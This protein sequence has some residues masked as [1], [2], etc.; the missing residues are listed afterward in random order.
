MT[1]Y[2]LEQSLQW[3]T[4][5]IIKQIHNKLCNF[6]VSVATVLVIVALYLTL[7]S[8]SIIESE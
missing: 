4:N 6:V 2:A 5:N 7:P 1:C 8:P 3:S